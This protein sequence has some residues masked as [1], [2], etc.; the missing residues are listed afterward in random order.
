MAEIL[1]SV[2][3]LVHT[4]YVPAIL[5]LLSHLVLNKGEWDHKAHIL[6]PIWATA[7]ATVAA[8]N[9]LANPLGHSVS[10][11]LAIATR[12]FAIYFASLVFSILVYRAFFH[13]LHKVREVSFARSWES[14]D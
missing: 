4:I 12:F 2:D 7:F 1:S 11:G 8:V 10:G 14:T 9:Y 13:R 6:S 3:Q 5:G